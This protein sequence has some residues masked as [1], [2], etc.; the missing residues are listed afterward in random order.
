MSARLFIT[1]DLATTKEKQLANC[2]NYLYYLKKFNEKSNTK[3]KS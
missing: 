2:V 3:K 1:K